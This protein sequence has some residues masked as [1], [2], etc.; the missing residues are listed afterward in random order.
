[1]NGLRTQG[2]TKR[3]GGLLVTDDV[4]L[5]IRP[6]ELHA[7]IGPNGAGK[8]T[9]IN[10]L[11]G[12]LRPDS[13]QVWFGDEEVTTLPLHQRACRGLLRSYQITSIFEEFT[14]M[15]NAVLA[16]VGATGGYGFWRPMM[17]R[18]QAC[19]D[20]QQALLATRLEARR[21]TLA[22]ELGYGERRQL[23]L[24]M[25]LAAQPRL[26]LLDEPMAGMSIEES[27]SV[28]QL[29]QSLKGRYSMLLIE[30]DMDAVFA[31]ADRITVLVSGRAA[32]CGTPDEIRNHPEVRAIYLGDEAGTFSGAAHG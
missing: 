13:G 18:E 24:A 20:A 23:E 19:Q 8:T 9:L 31:L 29:L 10:Q 3:F 17:A 15:E 4:S 12:E 25:A 28:V 11:S 21:D 27:A 16:A 22:G 5:D 30:H 2:L 6:G 14:V 1:M 7:I 32:F 26:L